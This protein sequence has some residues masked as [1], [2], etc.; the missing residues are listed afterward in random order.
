MKGEAEAETP[1]ALRGERG[2]GSPSH[3]GASEIPCASGGPWR[4]VEVAEPVPDQVDQV[5]HH[6]RA[7]GRGRAP[8]TKGR[9][10]GCA[11]G[12]ATPAA[13]PTG[14]GILALARSACQ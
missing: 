13:T 5:D 2:T 9:S 10:R 14:R 3:L 6:P 8:L 7:P 1:P 4:P 12:A 11:G